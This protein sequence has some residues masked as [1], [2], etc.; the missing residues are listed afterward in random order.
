[1]I[2]HSVTI[3]WSG[4]WKRSHV[5]NS[6][7]LTVLSLCSGYGG[8]ELGLA[9]ALASPLQI[10]GVEVEAFALA[11]LE[12]KAARGAL[13]IEAL[14]PD[15]RAFPAERFRR[16]FD[17]ITAGYPCQ[18]FSCSGKRRGEHDARHFWPDIARII[19]ECEPVFVLLENVKGHLSL[20]IDRVILE[21]VEMGYCVAAGLFGAFEAGSGIEY[22][23][24]VFLLAANASS[25]RPWE[26]LS[27]RPRRQER[28]ETDSLG[29][30]AVVGENNDER[31]P[32]A[33][34]KPNTP[35]SGRG[36][37][38]GQTN[39]IGRERMR[40]PEEAREQITD[41]TSHRVMPQ[42]WE[43]YPWE[44]ERFVEPGLGR[45]TYGH[46]ARVD[47][48]RLL[49]NGVVPAQAELAFRTLYERIINNQQ[50]IVKG[51][52]D[53]AETV[54]TVVCFVAGGGAGLRAFGPGPAD[55]DVD[56]DDCR[57]E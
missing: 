50:S 23:D 3:G 30:C 34:R 12:A 19:R 18:P 4:T 47:R 9:G 24:R 52:S 54:E 2:A 22:G 43:Q 46:S 49:G 20:G 15:L 21:L 7:T 55:G 29:D 17:I 27:I 8:I 44:A 42:G 1:M 31:L 16:C 6:E 5:D 25:R 32:L 13:A 28:A 56:V 53:E 37:I 26:Y 14:W 48:I 41:R 51:T 11:N 10:V 57:R 45:T 35:S 36:E 39:G 40:L 33:W 38:L